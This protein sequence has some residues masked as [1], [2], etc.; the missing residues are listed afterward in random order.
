[1]CASNWT[2]ASGPCVRDTARRTGSEIEW[3]P[4]TIIGVAPAA[5]MRSTPASIAA[6]AGSMPT[7]GASTS[8]ASTIVSVSNGEI[9][10][11]YE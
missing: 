3:S 11:K 9:F 2:S 5:R 6:Y 7:G 10:W 4:P 1:M 8:P